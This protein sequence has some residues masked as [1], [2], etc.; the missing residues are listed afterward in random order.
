MVY[1]AIVYNGKL[2]VAGDFS[3]A[4]GQPAQRIAAWDGAAWSPLGLGLNNVATDL[5]V[6][7]DNLYASGVFQSGGGTPRQLHRRMG[8]HLLE[9]CRRVVQRARLDDAC[10][11]RPD[12][13]WAASSSS[14]DDVQVNHLARWD[15]E[16][17]SAFGSGMDNF[18]QALTSFQGELVVGG[19]FL[20]ADDV[21]VGRVAKW[22]G[23]TFDPVGIGMEDRLWELDVWAGRLVAGGPFDSA[24]GTRGQSHHL[25][26][27]RELAGL[28]GRTERCCVGASALRSRSSRRRRLRL[29][30]ARPRPVTWRD[31]VYRPPRARSGRLSSRYGAGLRTPAATRPRFPG[32]DGRGDCR[33][34]DHGRSGVAWCVR[35]VSPSRN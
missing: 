6:Y 28:R 15:G 31:G 12:S 24:D 23:E 5:V 4:G 8:R 7:R 25:V 9:T 10:S 18:V 26:G 11:R 33:R 2:V 27:W 17:W 29:R 32:M 34:D 1:D 35:S 3:A 16:N 21:P 19:R 30:R 20:H 13:S 22:N 14:I